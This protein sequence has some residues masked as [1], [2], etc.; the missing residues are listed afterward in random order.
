MLSDPCGDA[1]I[2]PSKSQYQRVLSSSLWVADA[3]NS[4]WPEGTE[5]VSIPVQP[6]IPIAGFGR[7]PEIDAPGNRSEEGALQINRAEMTQVQSALEEYRPEASAGARCASGARK[8][9]SPGGLAFGGDKGWSL[10]ALSTCPHRRAVKAL[11]RLSFPESRRPVPL[12][13]TAGLRLK[14]RSAAQF[15]QPWQDQ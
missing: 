6:R 10:R 8:K 9:A 13:S 15:G 7:N 3:R 4:P 12:S 14:R 1:L 5:N 11:L 2:P